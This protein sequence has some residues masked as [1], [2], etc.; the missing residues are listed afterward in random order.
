MERKKKTERER[1]NYGVQVYPKTLSQYTRN[2][3]SK[4]VVASLYTRTSCFSRASSSSEGASEEIMIIQIH[5]HT[6]R[7]KPIHMNLS[8]QLTKAQHSTSST[9]YTVSLKGLR[10][11][12]L[13]NTI[14][15]R[16][17]ASKRERDRQRERPPAT[18]LIYNLY[19]NLQETYTYQQ[20]SFSRR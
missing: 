14:Q 19:R 15:S 16:K 6:H 11:T 13:I 2:V 17:R 20:C 4:A 1:E 7:H 9:D 18:H 5:T 10:I 12:R 3:C 8:A